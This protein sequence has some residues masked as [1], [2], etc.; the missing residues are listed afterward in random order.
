MHLSVH[1]FPCI[2]ATN[3]TYKQNV[4]RT[5]WLRLNKSNSLLSTGPELLPGDV[6]EK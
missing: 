2:K 1:L 5:A 6:L 4:L 3:M